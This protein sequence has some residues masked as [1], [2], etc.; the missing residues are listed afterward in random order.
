MANPLEIQKTIYRA[1]KRI[2][3]IF[4]K[5]ECL[6]PKVRTIHTYRW[7]ATMCCWHAPD[8]ERSLTAIKQLFPNH[9]SLFNKT[10]KQ[11]ENKILPLIR[12]PAHSLVPQLYTEQMKIKRYRENTIK[13][14][15]SVHH[16]FFTYS[17]TFKP[18]A[19][20]EEQIRKYILFLVEKQ[21]ITAAFQRQVV[22][23][24]KFYYEKVLGSALNPMNIKHPKSS[25]KLPIVLSEHEVKTLLQQVTNLKH[26]CILYTIYAAG[27]RRSEVINLK[28][29]DIDSEL[30]CIVIRDAKGNKDRNTLLNKK[31]LVLLRT[32]YQA[33]KTKIYLFEAIQGGK[34]SVTSIRKIL[35]RALV[36][37]GIK[38]DAHLHTLRHSFAT[39]LLERGTDL[40]YIQSLLGHSSSKTTEIYTHITSKRFDTIRSPL[41]EMNL[42]I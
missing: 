31:L 12:N 25:K 41:D 4:K 9:S 13:T 7:S 23:T 42:E 3:L 20:T 17:K 8:A 39:H 6:I 10:S 21:N 24:I 18:E 34:Y 38:K 11:K 29:T 16:T 27:L 26:T 30:T 22:N 5:E 33:Y 19:I 32:Y 40:R 35:G 28:L 2:K 37:S 1:E 36:L 15:S 14:Y